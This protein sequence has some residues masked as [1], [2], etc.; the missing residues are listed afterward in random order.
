MSSSRSDSGPGDADGEAEPEIVDGEGPEALLGDDLEA[1][2]SSLDSADASLG[3]PVLADEDL[4]AAAEGEGEGT[5]S[6]KRPRRAADIVEVSDGRSTTSLARS[7]PLTVYMAE[8]RRYPLLSRE[9]E[10][11]LAVRFA[12]TQDPKIAR[13]LIT[14]NLRL[15]VKIA[16]EYRRA[17]RNLLDLVQEGNLG[18]LQAVQKY[19]PHRGVKLSSYSAWWIRAY[20]LKFILNNWR[21]VKI[22]T[23]QAQRKLFFNLTKEREK[24]EAAG[25]VPTTKLLAERLSVP[26]QEVA[27]M[28][29]RLAASEAS[30]D[31]PIGSGDDDGGKRTHLD[32]LESSNASRPDMTTES[33]EFRALLRQKLE[34]FESTLKGREQTLFHDRL[35]A[36]Q[37]L[38]LQE[39]GERYGISRERARQIEARLLSRLK[40]YLK[41]ELGDAVQVAMGLD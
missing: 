19:D 20:M 21:L 35:M 24:L 3:L 41:K 29:L 27:E 11:E 25:F 1:G 15:V 2:D 17:Y 40:Q 26:E 37:P 14:A 30:L 38:T 10:H 9:E 4:E 16:H 5:G 23:T 39:V 13:R 7:D 33:E 36:D 12:E 18:L 28:Q 32:M 34:A 8:I 31:A 22:G 6:R